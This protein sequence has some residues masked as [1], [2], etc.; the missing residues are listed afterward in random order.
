MFTNVSCA[1][2]NTKDLVYLKVKN[3]AASGFDES[4][5][6]APKPNPMAPVDFDPDTRWSSAY[7][8]GEWIYFDFGKPKTV[9]KIVI[10]W[11]QAYATSYEILT[12]D[13]S[14]NWKRLILLEGQ[15]GGTSE[16]VFQPVTCRYVKLVGLSRVNAEWGISIWEFEPYGPKDKNPEDVALE[17]IIGKKEKTAEE[18][19][20]EEIKL[21]ANQIV[22]SPGPITT[23]EFQRGVNY[24]SWD[25]NEL[26]TDLSDYNLIH[27]SRL[28]VG[29]IAL[30]VVG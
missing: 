5:D 11:E 20:L 9:S 29:H 6:W 26:G 12:S 21:I 25:K 10:R 30:M 4:P 8:D 2:E 23:A 24:T 19:K 3:A 17:A 16:L 1:A 14:Q 7:R 22:P 18:K 13:D 28:G 15:T 27:L